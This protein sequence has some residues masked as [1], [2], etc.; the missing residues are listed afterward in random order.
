MTPPRLPAYALTFEGEPLESGRVK[1]AYSKAKNGYNV[2]YVWVEGMGPDG[3][4]YQRYIKGEPAYTLEG[5]PLV[6]DTIFI[7]ECS[8]KARN[9][10]PLTSAVDVIGSG[11]A[12]C[13][14]ENRIIRGTW[15][16]ESAQEPLIFLDAAGNE[17]CRKFGRTWVQVVPDLD[18]V[19][20]EDPNEAAANTEAQ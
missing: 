8:I 5:E 13:V 6:A 10:D 20:F 1:L 19:S 16:K 14:V 3:G 7:M 4:Q 2:E 17:M 18:I 11:E 9:T 12:I 15:Q